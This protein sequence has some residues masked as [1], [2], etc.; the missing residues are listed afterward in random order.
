MYVRLDDLKGLDANP[1]DV[2]RVTNMTYGDIKLLFADEVTFKKLIP[3][4]VVFNWFLGYRAV[5]SN[6]SYLVGDNEFVLA[7]TSSVTPLQ[8]PNNSVDQKSHNFTPETIKQ[9]DIISCA[10]KHIGKLGLSYALDIYTA[11]GYKESMIKA[12]LIKHFQDF[13]ESTK[14]DGIIMITFNANVKEEVVV[15]YLK[16]LG[17]VDVIQNMETH[18]IFYVRKL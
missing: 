9:I 8:A 3:K 10:H 5:E 16:D 15:A 18:T 11:D 1:E 4:E 2:S 7:S 17:I 12:H 6:I 14:K 13:R